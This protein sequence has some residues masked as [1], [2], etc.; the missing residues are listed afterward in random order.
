[1][2]CSAAYFLQRMGARAQGIVVIEPDPTYARASTALAAGGI[3]QQFSTPENILMS[4]FGFGFL[5]SLG[6]ILAVQGERPD[7][8]LTPTPYLRLGGPEAL[9]RMAAE[10]R[11]QQSFGA[12]TRW[13]EPDELASRF[14][15][16]RTDGVAGAVLGGPREGLFD[17][18]SM[19]QAFRRK[20][21]AAGVR[22]VKA[23]AVGI[24]V[25]RSRRA[26]SAVR[27]DDA[28]SIACGALVNAAGPRAA[29]V[30]AMAGVRLPVQALKAHS[31]AFRAEALSPACPVV[32][33]HAGGVQ[34]KPEGQLFVCAAPAAERAEPA[35]EHDFDPDPGL[36]EDKVWPRLAARVPQFEAL[37]LERAWVGHIERCTLDGN[38]IIGA[39]PSLGNLY[40]LNGFSGH[41]VQHAP[42][43]GRALAE[44]IVLGAFRSIDLSRFGFA[45]VLD[46]GRVV[47]AV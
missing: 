40:F 9:L 37:K 29:E 32:L 46:G 16:M 41:G 15:W 27:L 1:M 12:Q 38:P 5:E 8:G 34:L 36:F 20:A 18:Y 4:Q 30:A 42:A 33:D 17:P 25:G 6:D 14:P 24:D 11:L 35:A 39:H 2:G 10:H 28:R 21:Q 44:L 13:L 19:L 45:R 7:A 26:V 23:R 31:F 47:E 3:R 43:A 22:F